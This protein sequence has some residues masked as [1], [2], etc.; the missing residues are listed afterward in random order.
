[1]EKIQI[2][3]TRIND[4][5]EDFK[6]LAQLYVDVLDKINS[7]PGGKFELNF[8]RCDFLRSNAVVFIA[9]L[10]RLVKNKGASLEVNWASMQE[11]VLANLEQNSFAY[12]FGYDCEPWDGNSIPYREDTDWDHNDIIDYLTDKWLGKGWVDISNNLRDD[13][14]SN[15]CEIYNN[16]FEHNAEGVGVY[17]C[18][19]HFPTKHELLLSIV[20]FGTGIPQTVRNYI[21]EL[22]NGKYIE[23]LNNT[24]DAPLLEWAFKHGN[25]T[26][27]R[28]EGPGGMG[29]DLLRKFIAANKGEMHIYSNRSHAIIRA[30]M[31]PVYEDTS[32]HFAGTMVHI[33]LQCDDRYYQYGNE[34]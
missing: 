2:P 30:A 27:S 31:P 25:T 4:N 24:P 15:V 14:I 11:A 9:G 5:A 10:L 29:L 17:T 34:T 21:S 12:N 8:T 32:S 18:G 19:Q 28:E 22:D 26:K 16:A 33:K 7:A 23:G 20:D 1:M 13:I 6:T 3:V